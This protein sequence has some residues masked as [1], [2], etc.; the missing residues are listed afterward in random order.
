MLERSCPCDGEYSFWFGRQWCCYTVIV[1]SYVVTPLYLWLPLLL[2][3]KMGLY[4]GCGV[5]VESGTE[6]AG[7]RQYPLLLST[8]VSQGYAPRPRRPWQCFHHVQPETF[9][10]CN[11][12]YCLLT[13][14]RVS[15]R[16]S[17]WV[18]RTR[19]QPRPASRRLLARVLN[20]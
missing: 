19:L 6:E 17:T 8:T 11:T 16:S 20:G 9:L 18:V 15:F 1:T 13:C 7:T 3:T 5:A 14:E 4:H 2:F 12:G 10:M